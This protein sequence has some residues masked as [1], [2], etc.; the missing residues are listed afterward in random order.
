MQEDLCSGLCRTMTLFS[1]SFVVAPHCTIG[2]PFA[3]GIPLGEMASECKGK[4]LFVV[5]PSLRAMESLRLINSPLT[6]IPRHAMLQ[7]GSDYRH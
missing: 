3:I 2:M 5:I 4:G 1:T 6:Y 7:D